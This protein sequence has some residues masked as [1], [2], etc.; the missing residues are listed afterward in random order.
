MLFELSGFATVLNI[1]PVKEGFTKI[2]VIGSVRRKNDK[3]EYDLSGARWISLNGKR[4]DWWAQNIERAKGS[5]V[6]IQAT[7]S[8]DK[9]GDK[10]FENYR[11]DDLLISAWP[12]YAKHVKTNLLKLSGFGRVL[13][14]TKITDEFAKLAII[15]SEKRGEKEV[16]CTRFI[17]VSG[18]TAKW[19]IEN[20]QKYVKSVVYFKAEVLTDKREGDGQTRHFDN[21]RAISRPEII[22]FP[23]GFDNSSNNQGAPAGHGMGMP[24]MGEM[25]EY[26]DYP[27]YPDFNDFNDFNDIPSQEEYEQFAAQGGYSSARG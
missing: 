25:P 1:L 17:N 11:V 21:Y 20:A 3:G 2:Q 16:V 14:V 13:S 5:V 6:N 22:K 24:P 18:A 23:K 8:T 27:E 9:S 7:A 10:F 12:D 19:W 26:P 15:N 4:A